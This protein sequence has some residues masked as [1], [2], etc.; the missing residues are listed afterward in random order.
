MSKQCPM[1]EDEIAELCLDV[2]RG[3][4]D[5]PGMQL[6]SEF[7]RDYLIGVTRRRWYHGKIT[8]RINDRGC[9][10]KQSLTPGD[11]E[12]CDTPQDIADKF[13]EALK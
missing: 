11:M 5:K 9:S 7:M 3:L 12:S 2:I 8:E 1:S 10:V 6:D 13:W 4:E